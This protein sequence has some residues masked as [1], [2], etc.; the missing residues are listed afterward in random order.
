MIL[1]VWEPHKDMR[2]KGSQASEAEKWDRDLG[3]QRE[4]GNSQEGE[5]SKC[6][7][8]KYLPC[9]ADKSLRLKS[10]HW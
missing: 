2:L 6:L 8:N 9:R 3:F 5:K 4:E 10:Y 7:V 1:C